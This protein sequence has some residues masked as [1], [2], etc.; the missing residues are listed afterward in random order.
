VPNGNRKRTSTASSKAHAAKRTRKEIPN[1]VVSSDDE[2]ED[3]QSSDESGASD[4]EFGDNQADGFTADDNQ[5]LKTI[6]V[7]LYRCS[8]GGFEINCV[9]LF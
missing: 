7:V 8:T 6:K 5:L 3:Q 1:E 4:G 9:R 2:D